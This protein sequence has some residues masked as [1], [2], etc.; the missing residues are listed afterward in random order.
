M[1]GIIGG[2]ITLD[3]QLPHPPDWNGHLVHRSDGG[4][5]GDLDF[6]D[7][8]VGRG[9]AV[10]NSNT[11]HDVGATGDQW[12]FRDSRAE[13]DFTYRA[14]HFATNAAKTGVQAYY[15]KPQDHA[16]HIG[17]SSGGRQGLL[18]AQLFPYDFD[19]IIAG[20]PGHPRIARRVYRLSTQKRLFANDFATNLAFDA[21]LDG[22]QESLWKVDLLASAVLARCDAA[23]GIKDG[24]IEPPFCKF[25]PR[26]D[27]PVCSS[28]SDREDC[29]T[30]R[31]IELVEQIY[32][33]VRNSSGELLYPGVPVGTERQW[34]RLLI[35]HAGNGFVSNALRTGSALAHTFYRDDPGLP[36]PGPSLSNTNSG[37]GGSL[38]LTN[39][40]RI[41]CP[42][43]SILR[44]QRM[45]TSNASFSAMEGSSCS[46]TAGPTASF[47]PNPL[48]IITT[49]WWRI[50]SVAMQAKR[51][52]TCAC[53]WNRAW[54]IAEAGSD[55]TKLTT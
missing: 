13:E 27:L 50:Y 20:A 10:V 28:R 46:I 9:Y 41:R 34:P 48:L 54:R 8:L 25:D 39:S 52:S 53:S 29:L 51:D 47:H 18:A 32:D 4:A 22:E 6:S 23:D 44:A 35:P 19:G 24:I 21:D 49:R 45:R 42:T 7:S 36:L 15:R 5:D 17:C 30:L 33:G 3:V 43:L 31:Q 38:K 11:G 14:G 40:A 2:S 12:A 16:F 1:K 37:P 55:R 26:T